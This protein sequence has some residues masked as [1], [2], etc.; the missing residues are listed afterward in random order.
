MWET[1]AFP[2]VSEALRCYMADAKTGK[3]PFHL[4]SL[5][6]RPAF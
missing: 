3:F 4:A 1:M 5:L 6:D 2:V